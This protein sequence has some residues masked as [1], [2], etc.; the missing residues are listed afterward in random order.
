MLFDTSALLV[1]V[2]E[3]EEALVV[4][5]GVATFTINKPSAT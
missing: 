1:V 4:M 3:T 2:N 5:T